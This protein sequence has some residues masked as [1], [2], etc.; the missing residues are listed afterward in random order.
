MISNLLVGT[1]EDVRDNRTPPYY[2]KYWTNVPKDLVVKEYV[3]GLPGGRHDE[4]VAS[5]F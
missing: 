3:C 1:F 4:L 2:T 5:D